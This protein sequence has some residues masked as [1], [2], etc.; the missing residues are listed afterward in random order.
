MF[1]ALATKIAIETHGSKQKEAVEDVYCNLLE[2]ANVESKYILAPKETEDALRKL[3][4]VVRNRGEREFNGKQVFVYQIWVGSSKFDT[5]QMTDLIELAL[6]RCADL[7]VIDSET[8]LIRN[9]Y[10]K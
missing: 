6:N 8:E 2:E 1:W 7:G 10:K 5:E 9:E 4:R 3:F